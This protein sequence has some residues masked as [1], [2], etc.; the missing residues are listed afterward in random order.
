ML[1]ITSKM[2]MHPIFNFTFVLRLSVSFTLV[3]IKLKLSSCVF[4]SYDV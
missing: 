3:H 4:L 1:L 2:S